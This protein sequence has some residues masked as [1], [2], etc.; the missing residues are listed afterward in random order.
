[1]K[2]KI[3][4]LKKL[5]KIILQ[6]KKRK[7]KISLCHGVFDL[8]HPGHIQHFEQAKKNSD[9]LIVSITTDKKV[10]KGPGRPYFSEKL[11]MH[12]LSSLQ[13]VDYVVSSNDKS[14]VNIIKILKP[15]YYVKGSDY[16]NFQHDSTGKIKLETREVKKHGGKVLFTGGITFSSS[17]L[18]NKEFFYN[19]DQNNF[20]SRLKK[21]YSLKIILNSIDKLFNNI[22]LV[23]GDTIIDEYV[24][25]SA[26]GKS[27]KESYMVLQEKNSEKYLGGVLPIAQNLAEVSRKVNLLTCLG[28]KNDNKKKISQELKKN[29]KLNFITKRGS[30]TIIKKRFIDQI[31]N[32]KLLGI[33]SLDNEHYSK[34]DET[35]L[36]RKFKSLIRNSDLIIL[37]DYGHGF[38]TQN[39]IREIYKTK[40]F[41]AINAQVNSSSFGYHTITKYKKANLVLMNELELRHELRDKLSTRIEL[42]KKLEKRIKCEF[43]TITH[44]KTGATIYSCKNKKFFHVPAFARKVVD[45]VGAG[46]ALFP[47]LASCLKIKIPTDISLFIA[48]ISAAINAESYAN[49]TSLNLVYFKKF[50]EHAIK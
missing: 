10:I 31:D 50:I 33:Y 39:F 13:V 7:K 22:P 14:A 3:L 46:D 17:N 30:T 8:L 42:I 45:K 9:I 12:A 36:I 16:K 24:F 40:K 6:L 20:I 43:I 26:V 48:S 23:L 44:G 32:T 37:S 19:K 27:G 18:I 25:C 38:F 1:M 34:K 21:N 29:I 11:R 5:S 41:T 49:K 15:D 35:N 2:S 28:L 47:I 4:Q